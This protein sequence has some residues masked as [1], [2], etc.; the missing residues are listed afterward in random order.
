MN[1]CHLFMRRVATRRDLVRV[2]QRCGVVLICALVCLSVATALVMSSVQ[3]SLVARRQGRMQWQLRQTQYLL[4][5][6]IRRAVARLDSDS[7]YAGESWQPT[8]ALAGFQ[9]V[10]VEVTVSPSDN[11]PSEREVTVL[12]KLSQSESLAF[13]IQRSHRF[14]YSPPEQ[15]ETFQPE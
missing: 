1:S 12:A 13:R 15:T 9:S 10:A 14:L 8:A 11:Q 5:A 6:G 4:D 2:Q 7:D 3:Q